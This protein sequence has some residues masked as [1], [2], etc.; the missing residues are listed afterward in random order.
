VFLTIEQ[1]DVEDLVYK[2]SR[3]SDV[4]KIYRVFQKTD[5]LFYFDDNFCK[6]GLILTIFD[7]YNKKFMTHTN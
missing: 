1:N 7:C 3:G 6:Y 5:H 2:K 4:L